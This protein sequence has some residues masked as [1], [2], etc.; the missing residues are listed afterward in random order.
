M[1]MEMILETY[2]EHAI[3]KKQSSVTKSLYITVNP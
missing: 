2:N 3:Q 1:K